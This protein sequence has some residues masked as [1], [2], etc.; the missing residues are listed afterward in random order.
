MT[1]IFD[2]IGQHLLPVLRA[3]L[4][5]SKR[6]DFCVGYFN[7][8]GWG[9]IA[10]QIEHF[11]G[12]EDSCCRLLIGMQRL[13]E[14]EVHRS[15]ALGGDHSGLDNRRVLRWKKQVAQDFC[16][17]L[18]WGVPT[19]KDELALR[20]LQKQLQEGK[21]RVKF[22]LRYPLHAKLYLIHR[23]DFNNPTI[24]FLGSSNLTLSGLQNQGELNVDI[25]DH[26]ACLKLQRWFEAR[27]ED[28]WCVD[29]SEEIIAAIEE[30][31]ARE[32]LIPPYHIY[33]K[34]AYHL[35]SE[36][37]AG[38]AEYR[39]PRSVSGEL[40]EFQKA[41]V[42]IAAR[43]L[44]QRGGVLV[45]DVV[46]L[47]KTRIAATLAKILEEDFFLETLIICPKNL[48]P[49]WQE[50]VYNYQLRGK[51]L[52]LSR[53]Q[54]ELPQERRYRVVLIDESHNL[55]NRQGKR[56][57]AIAEYIALN[58]SR[59]ILLTAT[60]YNK[61]Y[62]D[63]SSQLRLFIN[64]DQDL[65]TRPEKLLKELG[66]EM[67]FSRKHQAP[68]RSLA[69]FEKSEYAD[70]WRELMRHYMVR[71]TRSF[72]ENNYAK[73]DATGRKYLEYP[74]GSKSYF[75]LRKPQTL[76]FDSTENGRLYSEEMVN[77]LGDLNL[78]RYGLGNY[79]ISP[80]SAKG[81]GMTGEES[82]QIKD[83]SRGGK[84]LMGFCR[85]NLFKRLE[86]SGIAF[87]QS[88][89]RHLLRNYIFLYGIA[90]QLR[91]PI[92]SQDASLLDPQQSDDDTLFSQGEEEE[93]AEVSTAFVSETEKEYWQRAAQVYQEYATRYQKRFKWI[94]PQLF[95]ASLKKDL[96]AD[97][98]TL[99]KLL[100][101]CGSWQANQDQKLQVLIDLVCTT[102]P[103]EKVLI[104]SQF[105]DTVNYLTTEMQKRGVKR[106]AGVTGSSKNP[107]AIAWDFSPQSNGKPLPEA[108]QL[109]ILIATDVLSEGLNLQ[110]C[111]IIV[112]YDL[113]W[114]I[115]RLIQRAGRV[116]RFG[117]AAAKIL[118]YSFLPAEG[119]EEVIRLRSRL[120][121]RLKENAEV[122]GT[123]EAFFEDDL[124][125]Q[126]MLDLYH[127]KSGILDGEEDTEVDLTSEAY[128]IW[129]NAVDADPPLKKIIEN[130]NNVVYATRHHNSTPTHPEGVLLYMK[131]AEGND[132]L[133][134][135]NKEGQSVTESQF[136]ILRAAAC[137]PDT[138]A[139]PHH[140][141]HHDLVSQ[142]SK[143]II[144]TE[145]S[146]GGQ[147][148]RPSGARFRSYERLKRYS[149][150]V[151]GTLFATQDLLKAINQI[152]QYPL[153]QSA[154][155]RLNRS[156]KSGVDDQQL[157][158]LVVALYL[159][160]RLC[161]VHEEGRKQE[162][163]IICSM[164][165]FEH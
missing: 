109:R 121:Q 83:L 64:E 60:P 137:H 36:A 158:E 116:D 78:P 18:S 146:S 45:G 85:T 24:G 59:C 47:G 58:E 91:L 4:E 33:L 95:K 25:L 140:P 3:T 152:Y 156:L 21:V 20:Q 50:Y 16:Q 108:K 139:F 142:G 19:N 165:L 44:N 133:A 117:Q 81:K 126:V 136:A 150:Q 13:P 29:V 12:K 41:A 147:L 52:S 8:R 101:S 143:F 49:M 42:K 31:W 114:A 63:L 122:V 82:A 66:G 111:A 129:K 77:T 118:C 151:K 134:W 11:A 30:S 149:T 76:T 6:A 128:Q 69:A 86:S 124:D 157:A 40:F 17:Q 97:C 7:L 145:A 160:D 38:L 92:G 2:N 106:V 141:Q 48:V 65:G 67:E 115:I 32:K 68:V 148:G 61:T 75:P 123:D 153:R 138:P 99:L 104:F 37:R 119:V 112:N 62:L 80:K 98:S 163:Q 54:T 57:R 154:I 144:D 120:R 39:I 87:L 130:L 14:T 94:R 107:A 71:R 56:Y 113:P 28:R 103:Q 74:D 164:G 27:W 51:V 35:S 55:R 155:D 10:A 34:I 5:I 162:P 127:E 23:D 110:D 132:A 9:K 100:Q 135:V 26:D 15:L 96:Q 84:R 93:I 70:D 161:L 79:A 159:D 88:L 22:F 105:A 1:R 72:I 131:T 90:H 102:H 53:V 89:D 43:H 125:E 46:G 73:E